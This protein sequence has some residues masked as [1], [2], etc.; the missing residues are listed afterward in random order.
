M[1]LSPDYPLFVAYGVIFI[2]H[3]R[4]I[5][6][7]LFF[8]ITSGDDDYLF[9]NYVSR[10]LFSKKQPTYRTR[11]DEYEIKGLQMGIF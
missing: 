7:N 8:L 6:L 2:Q 3:P 4:L 5:F 11:R 10:N 1:F 9:E